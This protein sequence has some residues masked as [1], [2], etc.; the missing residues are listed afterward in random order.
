M[1]GIVGPPHTVDLARA[2]VTARLLVDGE[3]RTSR[4]FPVASGNLYVSA[5]WDVVLR[6]ADHRKVPRDIVR[7]DGGSVRA[8]SFGR[9]LRRSRQVRPWSDDEP[10][11]SRI[12]HVLTRRAD[13]VLVVTDRPGHPGES[14]LWGFMSAMLTTGP[15]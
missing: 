13:V 8:M 15:R 2:R 3:G 11:P 1:P 12:V 6:G 9:A 4:H 5:D 10:R 7:L 14:V